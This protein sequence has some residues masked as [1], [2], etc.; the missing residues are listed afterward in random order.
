MG[1]M[2]AYHFYLSD[3]ASFPALTSDDKY[4]IDIVIDK[5]GAMSKDEIV[6]FMHN[7][8]AYTETLPGDVIQFKYAKYRRL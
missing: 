3:S 7:E 2:T 5:L 4:I 8:K 1:K 6:E